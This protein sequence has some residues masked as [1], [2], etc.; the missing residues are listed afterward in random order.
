MGEWAKIDLGS[1]MILTSVDVLY[2]W[3]SGM[4]PCAY[5]VQYSLD[6]SSWTTACALTTRVAPDNEC[7][8]LNTLQETCQDTCNGFPSDAVSY[9]RIHKAY[10]ESCNSNGVD[11]YFRLTGVRFYVA[12]AEATPAPTPPPPTPAP[13]LMCSSWCAAN[14]KPF[15]VKVTWASCNGCTDPSAPTPT[16]TPAPSLMCSSWCAA[17]TNPFSVK[18]TWAAC[19]GCAEEASTPRRLGKLRGS[20]L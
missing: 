17:N 15:S 7:T 1:P 12:P 11:N 10:G 19:N 3:D 6:A 18:V 2:Y 4:V 13:P 20:I 14:P 8:A 9:V 16:S 5:E